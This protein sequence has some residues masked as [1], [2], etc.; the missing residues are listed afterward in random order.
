MSA[1]NM[2][3]LSAIL[4]VSS[5]WLCSLQHCLSAWL[6]HLLFS[7]C[8]DVTMLLL[9]MSG[10]FLYRWKSEDLEETVVHSD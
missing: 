4:T 10:M 9:N 2:T 3:F 6:G 1:L 5:H 7:L 8:E